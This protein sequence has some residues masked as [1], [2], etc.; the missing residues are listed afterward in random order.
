METFGTRMRAI[1]NEKKLT[2]F[3]LSEISMVSQ[4]TISETENDIRSVSLFVALN[5]AL[6]L[7]VSLHWLATGVGEKYTP[8]KNHRQ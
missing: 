5:F 6:A 1:R 7:G 8:Q 3:E 2:Q 4:A